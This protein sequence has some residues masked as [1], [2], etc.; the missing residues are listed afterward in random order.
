MKQINQIIAMAS[1][2]VET[3]EKTQHNKVLQSDQNARYTF[4]LTA[5]DR[6]YVLKEN[7]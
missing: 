7:R 5:E 6:R 2:K 4:I 3:Y 1:T